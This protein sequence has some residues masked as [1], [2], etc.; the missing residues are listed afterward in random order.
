MFSH[1]LFTNVFLQVSS[2]VWNHFGVINCYQTLPRGLWNFWGISWNIVPGKKKFFLLV[3]T[4]HPQVSRSNKNIYTPIGPA[5]EAPGSLE[6]KCDNWSLIEISCRNN[7]CFPTRFSPTFSYKF[8]RSFETTLALS[9]AT[10]H[11]LGDFEIYRF[12]GPFRPKLGIFG[13]FSENVN[14]LHL[15][16][17]YKGNMYAINLKMSVTLQNRPGKMCLKH[18]GHNMRGT[19]IEGR[20]TWKMGS[21][22]SYHAVLVDL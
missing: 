9:T 15:T 13:N 19:V 21:K 4:R 3:T 20:L 12:D 5:R 6:G 2:F 10:K 16:A 18:Q 1:A 17:N 8:P 22:C 11:F 7:W 14:C